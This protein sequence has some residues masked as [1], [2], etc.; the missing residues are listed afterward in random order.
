[1][2]GLLMLISLSCAFAQE[3][4][5]EIDSTFKADS[6]SIITQ[7]DTLNPSDSLNSV[8][9]SDDEFSVDTTLSSAQDD[10]LEQIDTSAAA[11]MT[12]KESLQF[13]AQRAALALEELR[14]LKPRIDKKGDIQTLKQYRDLEKRFLSVIRKAEIARFSPQTWSELR[15]DYEIEQSLLMAELDNLTD[16]LVTEYSNMLTSEK[17]RGL[18]QKIEDKD[19][20]Y[21]D[22]TFRLGMLFLEQAELKYE[23]RMAE[24]D[25]LLDTLPA[26]METPPRP[27]K[28]YL[29]AVDKF[30]EIVQIYPQSEYVDDAHYNL[31]YI[32]I[33]SENEFIQDQGYTLLFEYV[34]HFP[35]SPYY[36]D[37]QF[38]LGEY[39]FNA[40]HRDLDSAIVHYK[41]V[42]NFP[43][44]EQYPRA[45]YRL[46]WVYY[47]A[48]RFEEAVA[49][50]EQTVD[51]Y[52]G[53]LEHGRFSNLMEESIE[54]LSKSFATD[55]AA[56][57]VASAVEFLGQDERRMDFFGSRMMKRIGE[58]YEGDYSYPQAIAAYDTLLNLFPNDPEAH[59]IQN[60]KVL[61][62]NK[63][64]DK[65]KAAE[66]KRRLFENYNYKSGWAKAQDDKA[67]AARADSMAE[68]RLRELVND[69]FRRSLNTK[70]REDYEEAI[71][72]GKTY[73]DYYPKTKDAERIHY[74]IATLLWEGLGEFLPAYVEYMQMTRRYPDGEFQKKAAENATETALLLMK[75]EEEDSTFQL[76]PASEFDLGLPEDVI[77]KIPYLGDNP[78]STAEILYL[79]AAQNY[80]DLFPSGEKA[81]YYLFYA[82]VLYDRHEKYAAA[83]HYLDMLVAK[84]PNSQKREEAVALIL[85]GYFKN[86][87]YA[88]SEEYARLIVTGQ[89]GSFSSRL[90]DKARARVR[91][92]IY[93][94]AKSLETS[95]NFLASGSEYKRAAVESNDTTFIAT[96]LWE[97]GRIFQK[98][99]AW[100][101]AI[102]SYQLLVQRAPKSEWADKSLH[103]M[104]II[105]NSNLNQPRKSGETLERLFDRYP[106]SEYAQ[107]ALTNARYHFTKIEDYPSVIRV[108]EK[109]LAAFPQ[110]EDAVQVLF[111]NAVTLL[112]MGSLQKAVASFTDFTRKFPDDPRNVEAEYQVGKYYLEQNDIPQAKQHFERAVS[113]HR[114]MAQKG[115]LGFPKYAAFSLSRLLWWKYEDYFKIQYSN[116]ST[117]ESDRARKNALRTELDKGYKELISFRQRESIQAVYN[118]CRIDEE[119][120]RAEMNQV[121]SNLSGLE[122]LGKKE[123]VLSQALPLYIDAANRYY[124]GYMEFEKWRLDLSDQRPALRTRIAALD[125]MVT[126][127]TG[128]PPDSQVVLEAQRRVLDEVNESL[129]LAQVLNDSCL[130][131]YSEIYLNN[132]IPLRELVDGL[133]AIPDAGNRTDRTISRI[134]T[135]AKTKAYALNTALLYRDAY[136]AIDTVKQ[137]DQSRKSVA[138]KGAQDAFEVM[139]TQYD[140][141]FARV[142]YYYD[143]NIQAFHRLV[144]EDSDNAENLYNPI[145]NYF[146]MGKEV[147]DSMLVM[148][149]LFLSQM[150]SDTVEAPYI[151]SLDS[152]YA[153]HVWKFYQYY[154]QKASSCSLQYEIYDEK[155]VE[156]SYLHE[157]GALLF[158]E[159][160]GYAEDY[161]ED[162]RDNAFQK[163]LDYNIA[164]EDADRMI[165]EMVKLD[166]NQYG[167]LM[168][169]SLA[170]EYVYG[171]VSWKVASQASSDFKL[172]DFDDSGWA[173]AI[174]ISPYQKAEQTED[175]LSIQ[176]SPPVSGEIEPTTEPADTVEA[177]MEAGE[178]GMAADSAAVDTVNMTIETET[179][180]AAPVAEEIDFSKL[181]EIVSQ[182]IWA[183]NPA[184]KLYFRYK[185][186]LTGKPISGLVHISADEKFALWVNGE[187]VA[188]GGGIEDN[189]WLVP[190]NTSVQR[191]LSPGLNTIAVETVD[192]DLTARG[193]WFKLEYSVMPEN[194]DQ[195]PIKRASKKS[196]SASSEP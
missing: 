153:A 121:I 35:D 42:L 25:A 22:Y 122:L 3:P 112:K 8:M 123:Q 172:P 152:L 117:V 192:S 39:F 73:V 34:E 188:E 5:A 129:R 77:R 26:G 109:Y 115:K 37:V 111:D 131:K 87:D 80:L 18:L 108:N 190:Y 125:S 183:E 186:N 19:K 7:A 75:R 149:D 187:F 159:N 175:T 70:Q 81:D 110:A 194:I 15:A 74:N 164:S 120:A 79:K 27:E 101:S 137:A 46:G 16:S 1:M 82:G 92:S 96:S 167:D 63:L 66:E 128:I 160:R 78:L 146:D 177:A 76:P 61:I 140:T 32:K 30:L 12:L 130:L 51:K 144:D 114:S 178:G 58:I 62:Y 134:I 69:D 24:F 174:N 59:I 136:I 166:P 99:A 36:P 83:R 48:D 29:L 95:E 182:P 97:A 44:D 84:F 31:A 169:L 85:D 156:G 33:N 189:A 38:R 116:T 11:A 173:F 53:E 132:P 157:T 64:E 90:M 196:A 141:L 119:L 165:R 45:L 126:S 158:D 148:S 60:E 138:V 151:Q 180:A 88:K 142:D 195:L 104:S 181:E 14:A 154:N 103:N 193:L 171:N 13:E 57:G 147:L 170:S 161:R 54:N 40:P 56:L 179:V 145:L 107:V 9:K 191:L 124:Q 93:F 139:Y 6:T 94:K 155:A 100:D 23:R 176:E 17:G 184:E 106:K 185:F 102:V 67:L 21:A 105:Y 150:H 133:L 43:D 162:F 49:F 41:A 65:D 168:D 4:G 52:I 55:T 2:V 10:T 86:Q 118:L 28:D 163:L 143:V 113:L 127:K 71:E 68:R 91:E 47:D 50:L 89:L 72:F 135:L 98:A 20:V